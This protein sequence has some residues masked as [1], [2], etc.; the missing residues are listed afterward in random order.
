MSENVGLHRWATEADDGWDAVL[1]GS[2]WDRAAWVDVTIRGIA[3]AI[4]PTCQALVRETAPDGRSG[5]LIH[6]SR[7]H[8]GGFLG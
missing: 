4:C 7:A 5:L 2:E 3:F 6:R 1:K 8:G